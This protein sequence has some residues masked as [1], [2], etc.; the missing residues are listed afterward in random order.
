MEPFYTSYFIFWTGLI[1]PSAKNISVR[2]EW[3]CQSGRAP[4]QQS[5]TP[6]WRITPC[7][8]SIPLIALHIALWSLFHWFFSLCRSRFW[9]THSGVV[10]NCDHTSEWVHW[11]CACIG[12]CNAR[13]DT[14]KITPRVPSPCA[15][16]AIFS[17]LI[18]HIIPSRRFYVA[19]N[20]PSLI[21]SVS[22]LSNSSYLWNDVHT[23]DDVSHAENLQSNGCWWFSHLYKLRHGIQVTWVF[24]YRGERQG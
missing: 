14:A 8:R 5:E 19:I 12:D 11:V 3:L 10:A 9:N 16:N 4:S 23:A 6:R 13:C 15:H 20:N 17:L 18:I 7:P 1:Y 24:R 21:P 22:C 2:A